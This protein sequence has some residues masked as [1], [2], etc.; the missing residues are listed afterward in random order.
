MH[1]WVPDYLDDTG[2]PIPGGLNWLQ[3]IEAWG[4]TAQDLRHRVKVG[5]IVCYGCRDERWVRLAQ[6]DDLE[7]WPDG[8]LQMSMPYQSTVPGRVYHPALF[9]R[10]PDVS[11]LEQKA[12]DWLA[13]HIADGKH[14]AKGSTLDEMHDE[15]PELGA[16]AGLKVWTEFTVKNRHLNL[17]A[18]GRK[19]NNRNTNRNG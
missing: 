13:Q 12:R 17:S 3:A 15:F 11:S 16:R 10:R 1:S 7:F 8:H 4:V 18:R 6:L 2:W 5:E 9:Y 19:R 14:R